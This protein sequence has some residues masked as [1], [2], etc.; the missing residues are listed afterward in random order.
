[1][2]NSY[3]KKEV[4]MLDRIIEREFIYR[5]IELRMKGNEIILSGKET[6]K[7]GNKEMTIELSEKILGKKTKETIRE[8]MIGEILGRPISARELKGKKTKKE[9]EMIRLLTEWHK[10]ANKRNFFIGDKRKN[11]PR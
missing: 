10:N 7:R 4:D 5:S 3:L 1:M 6:I 9:K 2:V 8:I 11:N